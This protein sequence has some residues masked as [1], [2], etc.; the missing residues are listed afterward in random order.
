MLDWATSSGEHDFRP[1]EMSIG[2]FLIWAVCSVWLFAT[3]RGKAVIPFIV[4]CCYLTTGQGISIGG[5]Y[6]PVFRLLLLLGV[7]RVLVKQE[8]IE[9]GLLTKDKW[10]LALAAWVFVASFGHEFEDGSGPVY[11]SGIALNITLSYFLIRIWTSDLENVKGVIAA[12]AIVLVP[13][14]ISMAL[15]VTTG[16]NLFSVFGGVSLNAAV[17]DGEL[18]ASGP[19]KH[20]ILAGTVGATLLPLFIGLYSRAR[21]RAIIGIVAAVAMVLTS[22]SS[23]PMMSAIVAI[24]AVGFWKYRVHTRKVQIGAVLFYIAYDMISVLPGYYIITKADLTGSST[25]RHRADLIAASIRYLS[26]WWFVGTDYTRHW[27]LFGGSFSPNH[28]DITNYYLAF[29]VMSG[30]AGLFMLVWLIWLSFRQVGNFVRPDSGMA[31]SDKFFVW[32]LGAGMLSH[33]ATSISVSYFDQSV[34][35]FWMNLALISS[36]SALAMYGATE[37]ADADDQPQPAGTIPENS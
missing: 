7:V 21:M 18:R 11:A 37:S 16:K 35:F 1:S 12:L 13:V 8:R 34:N 19:F 24:V 36:A 25:G 29:G 9:G 31:N 3:P 15:E 22:N 27:M 32:C 30:L 23:G 17:R 4:G 20:P 33:A 14:A 5:M 28:T 10:V 2:G 26:E 6:F